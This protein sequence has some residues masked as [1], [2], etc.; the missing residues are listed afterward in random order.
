M[1]NTDIEKNLK[2]LKYEQ[3]NY[4]ASCNQKIENWQKFQ[5]DYYYLKE[6]L[7]TLPNN[8]SYEIMVPISKVAFMP[9]KLVHTNEILV[10]LGDNWF[11]ERS[12]SQACEIIDR[13]LSGI[14]KHLE[15]LHK[16]KNSL[17]DQMQWSDNIF[18]DNGAYVNIEEKLEDEKPN[19][20]KK[21]SN[22]LTED[23]KKELRRKQQER[24]RKTQDSIDESLRKNDKISR[25]SKNENDLD[26]EEFSKKSKEIKQSIDEPNAKPTE[27]IKPVN[28]HQSS[29][30]E[31]QNLTFEE[32]LKEYEKTIDRENNNLLQKSF[33]KIE[34]SNENNSKKAVKWFDDVSSTNVEQGKKNLYKSL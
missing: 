27:T 16:E 30:Q 18:Q 8:L 11:T 15:D 34:I 22:Q 19:L 5:N 23:E 4:L 24:A 33:E 28:R 9:G 21:K 20:A 13:R 3:D 1:I 10:L 2:R 12:A 32:M 6:R 17:L 26:E 29:N 31:Q 25:D 7:R 14:R